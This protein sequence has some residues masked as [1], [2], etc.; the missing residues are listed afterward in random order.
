MV[1]KPPPSEGSGSAEEAGGNYVKMSSVEEEPSR[2]A[3]AN[4]NADANANANVADA[5]EP[6]LTPSEIALIRRILYGGDHGD[7]RERHQHHESQQQRLIL[8][9]PSSYD[10]E[11]TGEFRHSSHNWL[12]RRSSTSADPAKLKRVNRVDRFLGASIVGFQL[13]TYWLF[14]AEAVED[15]QKGVVE[16]FATH[17]MC[18]TND[19]DNDGFGL[20]GDTLLCASDRTYLN[21]AFVSFSMLAIFLA[22]DIQQAFRSVRG[23]VRDNSPVALASALVVALE[24]FCAFLAASV[25]ISQKLY[26]G[27]VTDAIEAGVGL[28]FVRELSTRAY[29]GMRQKRKKAYWSFFLVLAVTIVLG[30]L[31]HP[32]CEALLAP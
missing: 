23:A 7:F 11:Q 2:A 13:F 12:V 18:Q 29:H 9:S 6:P 22:S 20:A 30:M 4:A 10:S 24:V 19:S 1:S 8:Q 32:A 27:E 26:V 3:N 21:D 15:Y 5:A 28:L 14:A 17:D 16:V 25:S 31:V